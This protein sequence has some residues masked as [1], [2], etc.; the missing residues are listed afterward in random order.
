MTTLTLTPTPTIAIRAAAPG[1]GPTLSRLAALDSSAVPFGPT[2]I[3]EVDGEPRAALALRDGRVVADPF[4]RTVELV[5]LL[6]VHAAT[7]AESEERPAA[8][9]FGFAR[10]LGLAA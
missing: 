6:K 7:V 10:R 8:R 1:D 9:H 2:L 3:A 5:E 4:E